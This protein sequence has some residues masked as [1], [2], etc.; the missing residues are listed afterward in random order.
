MYRRIMTIVYLTT[1]I[2]SLKW[3]GDVDDDDDDDDD[4]HHHH[5]NHHRQRLWPPGQLG[6]SAQK[7]DVST[8]LSDDQIFCPLYV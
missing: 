4:D 2:P 5:L 6:L 7:A 8:A 1:V 3:R